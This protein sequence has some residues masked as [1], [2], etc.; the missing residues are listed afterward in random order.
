MAAEVTEVAVM[1]VA[2]FMVEGEGAVFVEAVSAAGMLVDLAA[3]FALVGSGVDFAAPRW[4]CRA[5]SVLPVGCAGSVR[6]PGLA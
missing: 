4:Q 6:P 3:A 1:G 2:A 5:R